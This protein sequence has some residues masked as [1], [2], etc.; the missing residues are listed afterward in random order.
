V[1]ARER[2]VVAE[3]HTAKETRMRRKAQTPPRRT[4]RKGP[5]GQQ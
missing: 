3:R 1:R 2:L 4:R 5:K